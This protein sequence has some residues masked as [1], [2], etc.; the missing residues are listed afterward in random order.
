[1]AFLSGRLYGTAQSMDLILET[2]Q[3]RYDTLN[4]Y[5]DGAQH[6]KQLGLAIPPEL[7]R[8]TVIVNW[9]RVVAD[10]RVDRLDM[11]R[12]PRRRR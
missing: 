7:K 12:L 10:S 3:S 2:S 1:M 11:K 6:L 5:Y 4:R 9:P 8:F